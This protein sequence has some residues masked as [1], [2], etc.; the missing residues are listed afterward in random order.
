MTDTL[1][2]LHDDGYRRMVSYSQISRPCG[3]ALRWHRERVPWDHRSIHLAY[4]SALH[5]GI[6]H[7]LKTGDKEQAVQVAID[8][9]H[10]AENE[11][12][13]LLWDSPPRMTH[14]GLIYRG[15]EGKLPSMAVCEA[16]LGLQIEG[17]IEKFGRL[18]ILALDDIELR[19]NVPLEGELEGWSLQVKL[20][21]PT[22]EGGMVDLKTAGRPWKED[23]QE[24][25]SKLQQAHLQHWAYLHNYS[26]PASYFVYHVGIRGNAAWYTYDVPYSEEEIAKVLEY[27]VKPA[28]RMIKAEAYT[29]NTMGWWHGPKCEFWSSC[30]LGERSEQV[31]W[32]VG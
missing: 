25:E 30:P 12:P 6:E 15:D 32:R 22:D 2:V 4:G 10:Q 28:I 5:E 23:P 13:P 20:D 1:E 19:V 26:K 18:G 14:A 31:A 21:I 29:P 11:S 27:R 16:G 8:Y 3:L 17:W 24:L 7:W 9:V